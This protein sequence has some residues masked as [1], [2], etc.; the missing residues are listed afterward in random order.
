MPSALTMLACILW[1]LILLPAISSC[2]YI[3]GAMSR[4]SDQIMR[5]KQYPFYKECLPQIT[6]KDED[7]LVRFAENYEDLERIFKLRFDVF[8]LELGEGLEVSHQTG[9]DQDEFD[10]NFHHLLAI[11]KD[12]KEVVGTYRIQ[13]SAMAASFKG[14]YSAGEFAFSHLPT[15][16]IENAV[17]IGRAC[18][19]NGHRDGAILHLL[20]KAIAEYIAWNKKKY[21]FGCYSLS[22]QDPEEAKQIMSLLIKENHIH[23]FLFAPPHPGMECYQGDVVIEDKIN[24]RLPASFKSYLNLGAKVCSPPAIDRLFKT[25]DFLIILNIED[26]EE[27]I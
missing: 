5:E 1:D 2:V 15:E 13:T 8:N 3:L 25:I 24:L 18:V 21:L 6:I 22:T 27:R 4:K 10:L 12:T 7:Y 20:W 19:A 9:K 23:P 26:L 14:F 11:H 17:E 16:I